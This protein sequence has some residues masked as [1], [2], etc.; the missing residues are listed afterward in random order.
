MNFDF[1]EKQPL[2]NRQKSSIAMSLVQMDKENTSMLNNARFQASQITP[3]EAAEIKTL[4]DKN[5]ISFELAKAQ[6]V[7]LKTD[8]MFLKMHEAK[9]NAPY[10]SNLLGDATY[11]SLTQDDIDN[12]MKIETNVVE[13]IWDIE[14]SFIA[15][16]PEMAGGAISGLYELYAM[17]QRFDNRQMQSNLALLKSRGLEKTRL[18]RFYETL[19]QWHNSYTNFWNEYATNAKEA[20]DNTFGAVAD[21]I[22]PNENR[23]N[24]A[25]K[26]AETI[27]Q[28]SGQAAMGAYGWVVMG[29][30]AINAQQESMRKNGIYGTERGDMATAGVSTLLMGS[31]KLPFGKVLNKINLGNGLTNRLIRTG[32][33]ATVGGA[34]DGFQSASADMINKYVARIDKDWHDIG[35]DALM[36]AVNGMAAQGI[37]S[38]VYNLIPSNKV[39]RKANRR[40][41]KTS[42][43]K[44]KNVEKNILD[45]NPKVKR[46]SKKAVGQQAEKIPN[47][48]NA[49]GLTAPSDAGA[50]LTNQV[51][52]LLFVGPLSVV[53]GLAQLGDIADASTTLKRTPDVFAN[54]VNKITEK[55]H[56]NI[57]YFNAVD[58]QETFGKNTNDLA[59]FLMQMNIPEA[60]FKTAIESGGDIKVNTGDY[61][62]KISKNEQLYD[63]LNQVARLKE[64][65]LSI[66]DA[67]RFVERTYADTERLKD[68]SET[69][70]TPHETSA[71]NVYST[72]M[73]ALNNQAVDQTQAKSMA[74]MWMARADVATRGKN[75]LPL[76]WFN[77]AM[78]KN[79]ADIKNKI[80]IQTGPEDFKTD[81]TAQRTDMFERRVNDTQQW[82]NA[83]LFKTRDEFINESAGLFLNDF[84]HSTVDDTVLSAQLSGLNKWMGLKDSEMTKQMKEKFGRSFVKYL[85]EGDVPDKA[86]K[87][88]FVRFRHWLSEMYRNLSSCNDVTQKESHIAETKLFFEQLIAVENQIKEARKLNAQNEPLPRHYFKSQQKYEGYLDDL[89]KADDDALDEV[90]RRR[91]EAV[92]HMRSKGY[93]KEFN[94]ELAS[95][96]KR[97]EQMPKYRLI[98]ALDN[99]S[100]Q[101]NASLSKA[102]GYPLS[103]AWLSENG[104]VP[105]DIAQDI[106]YGSADEMFADLMTAENFDDTAVQLAT[107]VMMQRHE[108]IFDKLS[109]EDNIA[110]SL[111]NQSQIENLITEEVVL[112]DGQITARMKNILQDAICKTGDNIIRQATL[113]DAMNIRKYAGQAV[114][115]GEDFDCAV[116]DNNT[117][118]AIETKHRQAL[119]SYLVKRSYEAEDNVATAEKFF[120]TLKD[121]ERIIGPKYFA[122]INGLLTQHGYWDTD[123]ELEQDFNSFVNDLAKGGEPAPVVHPDLFNKRHTTYHNMA[124]SD[125]MALYEGVKSIYSVGCNARFM[126]KKGTRQE[127]GVIA[128]NLAEAVYNHAKPIQKD[129]NVS[130]FDNK[131][132]GELF[133]NKIKNIESE[134]IKI[135]QIALEFD[136]GKPGLFYNEFYQRLNDAET[137]TMFELNNLDKKLA[138]IFKDYDAAQLDMRFKIGDRNFTMKQILMIAL[139]WGNECNRAVLL[140]AMEGLTE[141]HVNQAL[142]K[143]SKTDWKNIQKIW[144][145]MEHCRHASSDL[146]E[147]ITGVRPK[148]VEPCTIRTPFGDFKG[149]YFPVII[150][151][152]KSGVIEDR[153]IRHAI[154]YA[155]DIPQFKSI[156][157]RGLLKSRQSSGQSVMFD[158]LNVIK[159]YFADFVT[160]I[161]YR[162]AKIDMARLLKNEEL[163]KAVQSKIGKNGYSNLQKWISDAG[164]C[165][166]P[167]NTLARLM[168][169][170]RMNAINFSMSDIKIMATEC[171]DL[172]QTAIKVGGFNTAEWT[173]NYIASLGTKKFKEYGEFILSKSQFMRHWAK[174]SNRIFKDYYAQNFGIGTN[175]GITNKKAEFFLEGIQKIDFLMG[176]IS[177]RA[178]YEKALLEGKTEAQAVSYADGIMRSMYKSKMGQSSIQKQ[179][180]KN[181]W[182][183]LTTLLPVFDVMYNRCRR[184]A[185]GFPNGQRYEALIRETALTWLSHSFLEAYIRWLLDNSKKNKCG[186]VSLFAEKT[187]NRLFALNPLTFY[188][189]NSFKKLAVQETT[190]L[191]NDKL[192]NSKAVKKANEID[193]VIFKDDEDFV[194]SLFH[195]IKQSEFKPAEFMCRDPKQ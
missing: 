157:I 177:W 22:R 137:K 120:D 45:I 44:K 65:A 76:D 101:F 189:S 98:Q 193:D 32:V 39:Q 50:D 163:A 2:K 139:N 105:E 151:N 192:L 52:G 136:G 109:F 186:A 191:M 29:L 55:T 30:N 160:D 37:Y 8:E 18:Y 92:T 172:G 195:Q 171:F 162:E 10:F 60:D 51:R 145:L 63:S 141:N 190:G 68:E 66:H 142:S 187:I 158:D 73:S 31:E 96:K 133:N 56:S 161:N 115:A 131:I 61:V 181:A 78:G 54:I 144:N 129:V 90:I 40:Y 93:L 71:Q 110:R 87:P 12:L 132:K 59:A 33:N 43:S 147:R 67:K 170:L 121:C 4:A 116:R 75:I 180:G 156:A 97:I 49:D 80:D 127:I 77:R 125:F 7:R 74:R 42:N 149:G 188:M 148:D 94:D 106:G 135:E 154:D 128:A 103:S 117:V 72:M 165:K 159:K 166:K 23:Q 118:K 86:L 152:E 119:S 9:K 175:G 112:R 91:A 41:K 184:A 182:K 36:S 47:H 183:I 84:V 99:K 138:D 53:E 81:E 107:D 83:Y 5:G 3:D 58:L 174:E 113:R 64:D 28:I 21:F 114:K 102:Y 95:A 150:N 19:Y 111:Y 26:I 124:Y 70:L 6:K 88:V 169:I 123:F 15:P 46:K 100:L 35:Y 69:R 13:K 168:D 82:L 57:L 27:G 108:D 155:L 167:F 16:L 179:K 126:L 14:R 146:E 20:S 140:N 38:S 164:I 122:Q 194:K 17:K 176:S 25:T 104:C 11:A 24:A 89:Q 130:L 178:G 153:E 1:D 173:M 79:S 62:A 134:L 143:L 48:T 85:V 185:V 34:K